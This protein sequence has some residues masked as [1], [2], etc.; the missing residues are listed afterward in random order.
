[1]KIKM[2]LEKVVDTKQ[3]K[4]EKWTYTWFPT[5]D[6]YD[7]LIW[8]TVK[9]TEEIIA[10]DDLELPTSVDDTIIIEISKKEEQKKLGAK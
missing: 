9:D 10:T 5:Q 7:G 3:T 6:K 1:M 2:K 8:L 4:G